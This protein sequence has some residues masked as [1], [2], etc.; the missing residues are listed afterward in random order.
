MELMLGEDLRE[1]IGLL[2][3]LGHFIRLLLLGVT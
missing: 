1:A 2:D 3:F